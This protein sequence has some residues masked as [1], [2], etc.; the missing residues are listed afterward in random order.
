VEQS[1][2]EFLIPPEYDTYMDLN[3]KLYVRGKLTTGD[4]KDLDSTDFTAKANNLL[5]SLFTQCSITLNGTTITIT[6]DLYQYRSYL[7][8][9]LTYGRDAATSHL[10]NGL[11]YLDSGDI[12][13]SDPT[14]AHPANAGFVARW[15]RFKQSKEVQM[16]GKL[17][18]DIC[19]VVP[20]LLQGVKLN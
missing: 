20:Y 3:I 6:S 13:T 4:G 5:Q 18:R 1:D 19:N 7:E 15:N 16:I 12:Q 10:T 17:H 14:I 8:T 9:L 2:L 11:W